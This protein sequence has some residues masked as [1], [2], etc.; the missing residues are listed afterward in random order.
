MMDSLIESAF[1]EHVAVTNK[2]LSALAG[3]IAGAA[4]IVSRAMKND[5]MLLLCGNGG[6]ASDCQH[7]SAELVGRYKKDRRPLRAVSLHTDT[8]SL[9]CI[10]ND[11]GYEDIFTRQVEALGRKGDVLL[12]I[13][14]SGK[15][16]NVRRAMVKAGELGIVVVALLGK[17]GGACAALADLALVVPSETTARI[18]EM[19]ILIGH[20]ICEMVEHEL[21]LD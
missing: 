13:S 16:E 17:G 2:T 8:S 10:A 7:I 6:S 4:D 14:T 11:F 19:H 1:S 18:Q 5:G 3:G 20:L 21:G 15:S 9:T 12:A